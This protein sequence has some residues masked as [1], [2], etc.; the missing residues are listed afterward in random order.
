VPHIQTKNRILFK[1]RR[2][3]GSES[4]ALEWMHEAK[5]RFDG[6]T[7][8]QMLETE[9]GARAVEEMLLQLEHGMFA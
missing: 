8:M 6:R 5:Q 3:F 7:P 1:A 4:V 9:A 2:V